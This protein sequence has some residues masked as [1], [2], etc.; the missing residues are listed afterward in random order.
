MLQIVRGEVVLDNYIIF[1][2]PKCGS[3]RYAR[4]GQKTA[5]CMK[6]GYQIQVNPRKIKVLAKAR[7]AREAVEAVKVF[8]AKLKR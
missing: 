8:K 1:A 3:I 4:E 6:C 2:C 7:D 5:K